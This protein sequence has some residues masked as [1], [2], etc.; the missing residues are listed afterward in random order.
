MNQH[1]SNKTFLKIK[2]AVRQDLMK[3]EQQKELIQNLES[4]QVKLKASK[5]EVENE[6]N[7]SKEALYLSLIHI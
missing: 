4:Y 5:I 7:S 1:I 3:A 2:N 6:M